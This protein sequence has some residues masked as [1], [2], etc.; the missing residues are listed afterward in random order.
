MN[1]FWQTKGLQASWFSRRLT[2]SISML[3]NMIG[4]SMIEESSQ[5]LLNGNIF[6]EYRMLS[7]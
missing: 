5:I 2:K 1:I 3:S 7:E 6:A 4:K